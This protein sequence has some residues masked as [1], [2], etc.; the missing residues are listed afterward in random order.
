MYK[1]KIK[2][3][4]FEDV[5]REEDFYFNLTRTELLKLDFT[6]QGSF[7]AL[8]DKIVQEHDNQKLWNLFEE[9]ILSTYGEKSLDG[10]YFHKSKEISDNF[11]HTNAF[12]ELIMSF[13]EDSNKL[14]AFIDGVM[15]KQLR[16][17]IER[18]KAAEAKSAQ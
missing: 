10:K 1:L 4:D 5:E 11:S 13:F 12:D 18:Q 8:V 16:E 9:I 17:E 6:S 7:Q 15:P 2:Y 14:N 3:T